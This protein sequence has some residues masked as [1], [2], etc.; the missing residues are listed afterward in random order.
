MSF[1]TAANTIRSQFNTEFSNLRPNVEIAWPNIA[2]TP[3]S[4]ESWVRLTIQDGDSRQVATVGEKWRHPGVVIV[5]VFVPE[6]TGDGTALAIADDVVS[7]FQGMT[8][9]GIRFRAS[10]AE[11]VGASDGWYQVNVTTDFEYDT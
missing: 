7:V 5:Q 3:N 9:S 11:T 8:L 1:E 6:G 10:S 4:G 2:F